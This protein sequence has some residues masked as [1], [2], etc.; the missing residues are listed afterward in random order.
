MF[1]ASY[2]DRVS[3]HVESI[4]VEYTYEGFIEGSLSAIT[5][6]IILPEI[7]ERRK[8]IETGQLKGVYCF[9]PELMGKCLKDC[10]LKAELLVF[11]NDGSVYSITL[12]WYQSTQELT[13]TPLPKLVQQ[14][15]EKLKFKDIKQYCFHYDG[16]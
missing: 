3:A 1:K 8:Q 9:E 2:S 5:E 6:E 7:K 4:S 14:A 15:A 12:E 11:E 10:S 13:E 16:Y